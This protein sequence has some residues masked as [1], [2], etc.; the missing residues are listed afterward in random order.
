[1]GLAIVKRIAEHY[2]G[3]VVLDRDCAGG[4]AFI[5]TLPHAAAEPLRTTAKRGRRWRLQA[6]G[7]T[8]PSTGSRHRRLA[9]GRRQ[10]MK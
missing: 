9:G 4:T 2:G 7:H 6:A 3:T 10:R 8:R 5:V 1:M